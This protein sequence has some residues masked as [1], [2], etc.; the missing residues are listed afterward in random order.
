MQ[1]HLTDEVSFGAH[2]KSIEEILVQ[3]L[4]KRGLL[5]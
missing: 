4:E 1:A 3:Y 5:V 2:G